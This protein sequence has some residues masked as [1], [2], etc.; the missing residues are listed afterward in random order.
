MQDGK[1]QME[2]VFQGAAPLLPTT[3]TRGIDQTQRAN[4][5]TFGTISGTFTSLSR[6]TNETD[7]REK[8]IANCVDFSLH[9]QKVQD[10][11]P[12]VMSLQGLGVAYDAPRSVG[13]HLLSTASA[14]RR[15][16]EF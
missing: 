1:N 9:P 2:K 5:T 13:G 4:V 15:L 16:N 12:F 8:K 3:A 14:E 7:L 10:N 11:R 6:L